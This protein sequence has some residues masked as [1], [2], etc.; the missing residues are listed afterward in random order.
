MI[1]ALVN[2]LEHGPILDPERA[3]VHE[4]LTGGVLPR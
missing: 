2:L 4:D 3:H 1:P